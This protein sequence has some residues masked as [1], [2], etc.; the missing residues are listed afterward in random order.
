MAESKIV[1]VLPICPCMSQS[2]NLGF[3]STWCFPFKIHEVPVC[4]ES[5]IHV[6]FTGQVQAHPLLSKDK[7]YYK[8][9]DRKMAYVTLPK[10][11]SFE[12]PEVTKSADTKK[13]DKD[14]MSE[15]DM[16]KAEYKKSTLKGTRGRDGLPNFFGL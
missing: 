3:R 16:M 4:K 1:H 13:D 5:L 11:Y 2:P 9:D 8:D 6:S 15:V 14:R 12:I 7:D 10:N